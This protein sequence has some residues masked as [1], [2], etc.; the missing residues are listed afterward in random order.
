MIDD[1]QMSKAAV[2]LVNNNLVFIHWGR[3]INEYR[4]GSVDA[5]QGRNLGYDS[6]LENMLILSSSEKSQREGMTGKYGL[7]F[8]SVFIIAD[9]PRVLSGQLGFKIKGGFFPKRL[10][11]DEKNRLEGYVNKTGP[12]NAATIFELS[13]NSDCSQNLQK[14]KNLTSPLLVFSQKIKN[15][16]FDGTEV[17][18]HEEKLTNCQHVYWG[19]AMQAGS[20]E[21]M[22]PKFLVLRSNDNGALLLGIGSEGIRE[23][24][25][26]IPTFWVTAP[27][28]E[29]LNIGFAVNGSFALDIGRAQLAANSEA[30]KKHAKYLGLQ[31]AKALRELHKA[32]SENNW[33]SFCEE[34]GIDAQQTKP[35]DFW[36]KIWELFAKAMTSERLLHH[37]DGPVSVLEKLLWGKGGALRGLLGSKPAMPTGLPGEYK[38]LVRPSDVETVIAG[39]LDEDDAILQIALQWP[40]VH[41][42]ATPGKTT[43]KKRA[44]GILEK[45]CSDAWNNQ[46]KQLQ[47]KDIIN[48]EIDGC[49]VSPDTAKKLGSVVTRQKLEIWES[50]NDEL[51]KEIKDLRSFLQNLK[52]LARN[53][54]YVDASNLWT[55]GEIRAAGLPQAIDNKVPHKD[56]DA[57]GLKFF[58]ACRRGDRP[59]SIYIPEPIVANNPPD[60]IV[61]AKRLN[62]I[63]EWW[64]VHK[65]NKLNEYEHRL[66]VH[67]QFPVTSFEINAPPDRQGWLKLF[68]YGIVQT[69]GRTR[70]E[71]GRNFIQLCENEK[72]IENLCQLPIQSEEW[73][74]N[75]YAYIQKQTDNIPFYQ[76]IKLLFGLFVVAK[77][78]EDYVIAFRSINQ[79]AT[80]NSLNGITNHQT[81][82][83]FQGGGPDAPP[84]SRI[85]GIGAWFILREL[86]R[87]GLI[88]NEAAFPHC[89]VPFK[90]VRNL[91]TAL[92]GPQL[93]NL[94]H[95][96]QS[97]T[98]HKFLQEHLQDHA[99]F[100]QSF[101]IP[102]QLIAKD[103]NLWHQFVNQ[104]MP[105]AD[106]SE[107]DF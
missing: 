23:L 58:E 73:L 33:S 6:D 81:N 9:E 36:S 78:L 67:A 27:T 7:G 44:M 82:P 53:G 5:E 43:S 61:I 31:L 85:L 83:F 104:P 76:W 79:M 38:A 64:Q 70:I 75:L 91:I 11:P 15:L 97:I 42:I 49:N 77:K 80:I 55:M 26:D 66:Y 56:Y 94:T 24:P 68:L 3:R 60:A 93:E 101:D 40:S 22:P 37:G 19:H 4:R 16:N 47:L 107:D 12:A 34:L 63:Y 32:T 105:P 89:F 30:N 65:Q 96:E 72:W 29:K 39:I 10:D 13:P 92:G 71:A 8:K 106:D 20:I 99:T 98:I 35:Y 51:K 48:N 84:I 21:H 50:K 28:N 1:A 57:N 2:R 59:I 18:W 62:K 102:L 45:L 87:N 103:Q 25:N 74:K 90:R 41:G 14:F 46:P 54:H 52:F 17:A 86:V 69:L 95:E 100:D 88:T